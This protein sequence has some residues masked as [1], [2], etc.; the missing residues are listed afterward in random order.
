MIQLH[1]QA[2]DDFDTVIKKNPK[3]AHAFFRRAFSQKASK[4]FNLAAEDFERAKELDPRNAK[5][6]VNYKQL[7]GVT[8]IVLCDAGEEPDF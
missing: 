8:C 7:K 2:I 1:S 5:L 4:K 6:V 3:N